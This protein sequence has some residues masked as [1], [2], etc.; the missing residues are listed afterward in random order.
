MLLVIVESAMAELVPAFSFSLFSCASQSNYEY[1]YE[2]LCYLV[3]H[4]YL[5]QER[6]Q[7]VIVVKTIIGRV[8][9]LAQYAAKDVHSVW[10]GKGNDIQLIQVN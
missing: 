7:I 8:H 9:I 4:V 10:V 1:K 3:G 5:L 2:Y 6:A